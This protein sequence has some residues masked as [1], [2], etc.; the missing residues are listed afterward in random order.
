MK[1]YV[2]AIFIGIIG[3][4]FGQIDAKV[5][6]EKTEN[7]YMVYGDN[8]ELCEVSIELNFTLVNLNSDIGPKKIIVLPPQSLKN[9]IAALT[10]VNPKM[11]YKFSY[12]TLMNWG[13]HYLETYD[14]TFVYQLPFQAGEKY[15]IGQGYNGSFSHQNQNALDFTMP[16]GTLITA[17]RGGTVVAVT[18]KHF[19]TCAVKSC[20]EFNNYI[21]IQHSDGTFA[22]YTHI[23]QNGALVKK[24]DKV[25][26]G[27]PLAKSGNVGWSNGPHLHFV[28]YIQRLT[29][30]ET[31]KTKFQTLNGV[32]S[33]LEEKVIYER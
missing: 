8:A 13:N 29:Q 9:K 11:M 5:Y 33:Q 12:T 30:R 28:V 6:Y 3:N 22:E 1:K 25:T 14:D 24:G 21:T 26:M 32:I 18:Q 4:V 23:K 16:V 27:Q 10:V 2:L 19:K 31:L 20:A 7:G 15:K 17:A